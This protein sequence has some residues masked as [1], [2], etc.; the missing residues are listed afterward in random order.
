MK[1]SVQ[2]K[3]SKHLEKAIQERYQ[4][5]Q[6]EKFTSKEAELTEQTEKEFGTHTIRIFRKKQNDIATIRRNALEMSE[7]KNMMT[8]VKLRVSGQKH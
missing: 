1:W 2:P 3:A 7:M 6:M 5:Q 4:P 8:E